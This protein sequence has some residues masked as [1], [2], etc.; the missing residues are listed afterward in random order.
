[1]LPLWIIVLAALLFGGATEARAAD[2]AKLDAHLAVAN[3]HWGATPPCGWPTVA[4]YDETA[5][6]RSGWADLAGCRIM[7]DRRHV[8]HLLD[9]EGLCNLVAHEWGHLVGYVGDLPDDRWHSSDPEHLMNPWQIVRAVPACR[10]PNVA[11]AGSG[12]QAQERRDI[13]LSRA[14]DLGYLAAD[15]RRIL[16]RCRRRGCRRNLAQLAG[17]IRRV[18]ARRA[19]LMR[20]I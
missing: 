11:T 12:W 18:D 19:Q 20:R 1:M 16:R 2:A 5:P 13:V 4:I 3:Q 15:L 8:D 17:R 6:G 7:L 9:D 10:P 14:E